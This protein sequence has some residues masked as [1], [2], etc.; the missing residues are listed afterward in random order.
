MTQPAPLRAEFARPVHISTPELDEFRQIVAEN[1]YANR[2]DLLRPSDSILGS[3]E[4]TRLRQ[5]MVGQSRFGA[6]VRMHLGEL[7]T[8]LIDVPLTG[9]LALHQGRA[10]PELVTADRAAI[11]QPVGDTVLDE[12]PGDCLLMGIKIE[13][14][15]LEEQLERL[16]DAPVRGPFRL[17]PFMDIAQGAGRSWLQL[18][19]M[20]ADDAHS[21]EGLAHQELVADRLHEALVTGLLLAADH[22]YRE[23]LTRPVAPCRPAPVKRAIDAMEAH[24]DSS[25]TVAALAEIA[26]VSVRWLQ[27]GFR[28]H[29]GMAPMAYLRRVRLARAHAELCRYGPGEATVTEVAH[30]WGF[31]Q[32][33][34]FAAAYR[35]RYGEP[36]SATLHT[37][38]RS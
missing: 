25:F 32:L 8:Y 17:A 4:V 5:I 36:P 27:Q 19:R 18:A 31:V 7:G 37:P 34:R 28:E 16:L 20:V 2:I 38:Y 11:L 23:A 26:G 24:P 12:W 1:Y 29:V 13:H 35:R 21:P 33:S 14:A 9:S 30:R 15:T 22:P 10:E 6:D 3:I